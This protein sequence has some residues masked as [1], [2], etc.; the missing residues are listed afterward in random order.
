MKKFLT[1]LLASLSLASVAKEN[2]TIVYSWS[3]SDSITNIDRTLIA[4]ANRLQDRYNFLFDAK[5]GAGGSIAANHVAN[6]PNT[7]LA[8]SSAF[9]I[10]PTVFPNESHRVE[11]FRELMPQCSAPMAITSTRYSS[12]QEVPQDQ[13]LNIGTSGLGVTTHLAAIQIMNR[14]SGMQ[15]V[16]F[17]STSESLLSAVSG[18]TE[19]HV[20][21]LAEPEAW[22]QD[23]ANKKRLNVLGITGSQKVHGYTPLVSQGFSSVL[24]NMNVPFHLTVS[25]K[26][27]E[28][29][30]R[31]WRDI[32]TRAAR[33]PSVQQ[34]Y[35]NEYCIPLDVADRDINTWF[36]TQHA[37]WKKLSTGVKPN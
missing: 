27:P 19:F 18:Q 24:A 28:D 16:P 20:A 2:V 22:K 32:L 5:P 8:N 35:A 30:F 37:H 4:E 15:V 33:A 3:P 6:T 36:E 25:A 34:A 13:R 29:R 17:K 10:R 26:T 11:D 14:Y 1:I 21:F 9:F 12:W 7:I 23:A 31:D